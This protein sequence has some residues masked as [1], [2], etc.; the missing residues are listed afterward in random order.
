MLFML[1]TAALYIEKEVQGDQKI[2]QPILKYLLMVAIHYNSIGLINT[3]YRCDS[4]QEPM[5]V[6]SCCNLLVPVCQLSSNN[7]IAKMC[8]FTSATSA[9]CRTLPGISFLLNFP[10]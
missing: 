9:H 10:E 1:S 8:F 7:R 6:T 5:Q 4:L 3:Q 2:I